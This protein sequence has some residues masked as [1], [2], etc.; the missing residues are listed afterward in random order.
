L[1]IAIAN[2][3]TEVAALQAKLATQTSELTEVHYFEEAQLRAAFSFFKT[4][5]IY[6]YTQ[7]KQ[8]L[9]DLVEPFELHAKVCY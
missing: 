5:I 7:A 1:Q 8:A 9:D 3:T 4:C 2:L 6:I